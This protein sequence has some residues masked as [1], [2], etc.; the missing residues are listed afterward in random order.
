MESTVPSMRRRLVLALVPA[1]LAASGRTPA[2]GARPTRAF[3]VISL[4]GDQLDLVIHQRQTG[5][6]IDANLHQSVELPDNA[7]DVAALRA[8][9]AALKAVDA[10]A[11]VELLAGS[12]PDLFS[13][14]SRFFDGVRVKLPPD[15][16]ASVRQ[17]GS[18]HLVLLTKYHAEARLRQDD[19][20]IGS[21]KLQGLGFYIDR[22]STLQ[23]TKIPGQALGFIAPFAYIE[24]SLVDLAT[25]T[26][27]GR[28]QIMDS[29]II[30]AGRSAAATDPWSAMSAEEKADALRG[31]LTEQVRRAV[32]SLI[33]PAAAAPAAS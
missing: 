18:T 4:I 2:Q 12:A 33:A 16:E 17:S 9:R 13:R 20:S 32:T 7:L 28:T 1:L 30:S 10:D 31:M 26:V 19:G 11:S 6:H 25:S 14:Q 24:V 15:L 23:R 27:V 22:D 21:G 29:H 3:A 5:S 8:A